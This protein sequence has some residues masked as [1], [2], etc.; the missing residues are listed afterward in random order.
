ME[1][2]VAEQILAKIA[3]ELGVGDDPTNAKNEREAFRPSM[4]TPRATEPYR[5]SSRTGGNNDGLE[6]IQQ[7]WNRALAGFEKEF[8]THRKRLDS[9]V[10]ST[11]AAIDDMKRLGN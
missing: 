5:T 9:Y 4:T 10:A 1:D 6:A 8:E 7:D 11:R 3:D 2:K